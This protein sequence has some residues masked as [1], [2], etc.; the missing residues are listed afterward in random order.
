MPV[1]MKIAVSRIIIIYEELS[2]EVNPSS[3]S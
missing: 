2:D 3:S 1:K